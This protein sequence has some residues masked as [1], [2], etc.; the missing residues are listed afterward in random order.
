[1][2]SRDCKYYLKGGKCSSESAPNP[3][4]SWCVSKY[5]CGD[6]ESTYEIKEGQ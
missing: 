2:T 3:N 5:R 6:Y 1:M 4:H